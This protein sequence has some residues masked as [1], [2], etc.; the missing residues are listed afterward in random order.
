MRK[1][2]FVLPRGG[3][4][5]GLRARTLHEVGNWFVISDLS[6]VFN[7]AKRTAVLADLCGL[8]QLCGSAHADGG[9][10]LWYKTS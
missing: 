2:G 4:Y 6:S 1:F 3:E 10:V 5:V 8:G 9:Q 7:V